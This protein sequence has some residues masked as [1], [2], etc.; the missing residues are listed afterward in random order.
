MHIE[1]IF[2]PCPRAV[3]RVA[4]LCATLGIVGCATGA[5]YAFQGRWFGVIWVPMGPDA[6]NPPYP[7]EAKAARV[8]GEI[9]FAL[10]LD[11]SGVVDRRT[12]SVIAVSDRRLLTFACPWIERTRFRNPDLN[13]HDQPGLRLTAIAIRYD[14]NQSAGR[15]VDPDSSWDTVMKISSPSSMAKFRHGIPQCP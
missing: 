9:T 11:D 12:L 4:V 1:R 8:V 2:G 5:P 7:E 14:P 13:A 3:S 15:L 10:L 6:A